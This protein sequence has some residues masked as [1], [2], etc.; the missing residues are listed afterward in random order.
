MYDKK[1]C[2]LIW[3]NAHLDYAD[4]KDFL[5]EE[6]P[7]RT[8]QERELLMYELNDDYLEDERANLNISLGMPIIVIGDL[9]FWDGRRH[10]YKVIGTGN[11]S[12]CLYDDCDYLTW[13]VDGVGDLNC[14]A[15]HHD[16]T[17]H[18][19]YR[20]FRDGT[21]PEQMSNLEQKICRG[22]A[23][24]KDITRVTTKVGPAIAKV[25]GW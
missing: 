5:E 2:H 9:G 24:W 14:D 4:W 21:T 16:G 20:V 23:T 19:L 12:D 8:E 18:Y 10:G 3:S 15:S 13:Y 11:I 17:N 25:Y 6:Y 1:T 22:T 7:D